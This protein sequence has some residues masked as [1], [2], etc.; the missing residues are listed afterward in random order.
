MTS[1]PAEGSDPYESW[2]PVFRDARILVA[3][4]ESVHAQRVRTVL[5]RARCRE[6]VVCA[7]GEDAVKLAQERSFEVLLLDREMPPGM[8]GMD[9]LRTIR[10]G[11]GPCASAIAI[12]LTKHGSPGERVQ[13]LSPQLRV[14]GY[15]VK[16]VADD[17]LIARIG[18]ELERRT[19]VGTPTAYSNGPLTVHVGAQRVTIAG[20]AVE[21]P[22]RH[23][24]IL[25]L[26]IEHL[27][28][29][30]TRQMIA[31]V[32]WRRTWAGN[33]YFL[34][35]FR[36]NSISATLSRIRRELRR[37]AP[38]ECAELFEN[39]IVPVRNEGVR[40]LVIDAAAA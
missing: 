34:D 23:Y 29:P 11:D 5:T 7:T 38:E 33:D 3:E 13:A 40:M 16:P 9:V 32:G 35:E 2:Y 8:N 25:L 26:L 31:R 36:E 6:L 14:D 39:I 19:W 12:F 24:E 17:E 4:D 30:V 18:S 20:K 22:A 27:G 1:W 37:Q 28:K 21:V 10:T 15:I